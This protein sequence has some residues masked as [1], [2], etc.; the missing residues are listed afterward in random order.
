MA[1]G[2]TDGPDAADPAAPAHRPG[3]TPGGTPDSDAPG[4]PGP[5]DA[6]AAEF[7]ERFASTMATSGLPRMA[8]RVFATLIAARSRGLTA[9]QLKDSLGVSAGAVS[10]AVRWLAQ[11][12]L[13][14]RSTVAGTR[15]DLYIAESD[16]FVTLMTQDMRS[17]RS[18]REELRAGA[19][20]LGADSV[21]GRRMGEALE[22]FTFLDDEMPGLLQRWQE[23]R[24][25]LRDG[26]GEPDRD[27]DGQEGA[28]TGAALNS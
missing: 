8:S 3:G 1:H 22:F 11:V 24:R 20:A 9:A 26:R 23:H 7:V 10:G 15:Q 21:P 2:R 17:L 18:W 25:R 28:G 14:T 12:G 27:G 16:S 5:Q 13:I 4:A 6:A 19:E